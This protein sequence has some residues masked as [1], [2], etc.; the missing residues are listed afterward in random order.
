MARTAYID[1]SIFIEIGTKLSKQK[2]R[3]RELLKELADDK[4]RLY[5]SII[6]VQEMAVAAHRSGAVAKDTYSGRGAGRSIS[7]VSTVRP[8]GL[9]R[10]ASKNESQHSFL[11]CR[12]RFPAF[13]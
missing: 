4:V 12:L 7:I 5:T 13:V 10:T 8:P 9:R 6:T 11:A 2:K 3:I 1:T